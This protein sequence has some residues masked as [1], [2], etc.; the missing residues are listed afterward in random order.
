[1]PRN[2]NT[3]PQT[4]KV[5]ATLLIEPYGWHYGYDLSKKTGLKSGTLY[6]ILMRLK[7]QGL[8]ISEWRES[9]KAGRPPRHVYRLSHTGRLLAEAQR[10]EVDATMSEPS[11][12]AKGAKPNAS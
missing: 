11:N 5:F 3:S 10:K 12:L 4:R 1:M 8:L 6:P 9:A 2:P 7:A